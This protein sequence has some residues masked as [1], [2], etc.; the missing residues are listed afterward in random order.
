[1]PHFSIDY[2]QMIYPIGQNIKVNYKNFLDLAVEFCKIAKQDL[3]KIEYVGLLCRGSSGAIGA[4]IFYQKIAELYS[5]LQGIQICHV[6]KTGET[7][8]SSSTAGLFY[9]NRENI[10]YVLVDDFSCSGK[11]VYSIYDA[12][13]RNIDYIDY[14]VMASMATEIGKELLDDNVTKNIITH[15]K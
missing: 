9:T 1:M 8:H 11:T 3:E 13:K 12:L 5:H 7:A 6:K 14:I 10:L 2:Q 15:F 4:T